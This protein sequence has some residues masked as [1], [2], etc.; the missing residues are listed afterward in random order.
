MERV[1]EKLEVLPIEPEPAELL[2]LCQGLVPNGCPAAARA[3]LEMVLFHFSGQRI[4][5]SVLDALATGERCSDMCHVVAVAAVALLDAKN[6]IELIA[7]GNGRRSKWGIR[8]LKL[9]IGRHG[10]FEEESC[11]DGASL[12]ASLGPS[13]QLRLDANRTFSA[14]VARERL[15]PVAELEP[16][17]VE[18][19]VKDLSPN[20][21]VPLALDL[22]GMARAR[23]LP[24]ARRKF[25]VQT[26]RCARHQARSSRVWPRR[27]LAR[28]LGARTGSILVLVAPVRSG[29]LRRRRTRARRRFD[30]ARQ[31]LDRHAGSPS[32]RHHRFPGPYRELEGARAR[33]RTRESL[34]GVTLCYCR[35]ARLRARTPSWKKSV[36]FRMPARRAGAEAAATLLALGVSC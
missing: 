11:G 25:R 13:I 23:A 20:S 35:R 6:E 17:Y 16:E 19:P 15:E 4:E 28:I 27:R 9:K 12:G 36:S 1:L 21:A 26:L 7:Q 29:R 22:K 24:A 33:A 8:T 34:S 10:P 2:V 5:Q 3:A 32:S 14:S 30:R 31:G 18:E